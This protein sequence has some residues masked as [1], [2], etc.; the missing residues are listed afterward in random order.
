MNGYKTK[1]I[2]ERLL[3]RLRHMK[4]MWMMLTMKLHVVIS[5][6]IIIEFKNFISLV[7]DKINNTGYLQIIIIKE[8]TECVDIK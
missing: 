7:I 5:N 8:R 6:D 1:T 3:D 4:M 2:M